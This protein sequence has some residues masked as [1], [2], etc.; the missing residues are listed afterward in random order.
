MNK[1]MTGFLALAFLTATPAVA[2]EGCMQ[3][4]EKKS[5]EIVQDF[6]KHVKKIRKNDDLSPAMKKLLV[7]QADET[8]DLRLKHL[9]EKTELKRAHKAQVN[10]LRPAQSQDKKANA[11]MNGDDSD[12]YVEEEEIDIVTL[13]A[14][15]TDGTPA[16]R[17]KNPNRH[18][19][20]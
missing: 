15:E 8:R 1:V 13:P 5:E 6:E 18:L 7:K 20:K 14:P 11:S 9:K 4:F 17:T 12:W 10:A 19:M 2:K 3:K 16:K